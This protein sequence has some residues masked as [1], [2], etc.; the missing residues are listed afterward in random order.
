[1]ITAPELAALSGVRHG[2]FTRKGGVSQGGYASLNCGF[3]TGDDRATVAANRA[4]AMGRLDLPPSSLAAV[5]QVHGDRV[6][7]IDDSWPSADGALTEAD[8][9]VSGRHG[10]GLGVLGADCPPVLFADARAALI[11]AA[12]AGWRG[13]LAGV[14]DRTVEAME[15]LGARRDRLV[16]VVGPGIAQASYEVGPDFPARFLAQDADYRTFFAPAAKAG[17]WRF[18]LPG[19][20]AR[21]LT[22]AGVGQVALIDCDTL[23]EEDRFFSHRRSQLRAEPACGRQISIIALEP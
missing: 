10:I 19:Y 9:M 8:A 14:T 21:R 23:R 20:I 16:A 12:H 15:R 18:D 22:N 11:G 13:A 3:A 6:V 17:H 7:I 1:M 4:L 5:R 2:F